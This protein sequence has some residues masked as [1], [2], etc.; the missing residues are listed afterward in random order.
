MLD[1]QENTLVSPQHRR[2]ITRWRQLLEGRHI[3]PG[4]HPAGMAAALTGTVATL[5][6]SEL[7]LSVKGGQRA[8]FLQKALEK[9]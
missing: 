5:A 3:P 4:S 2:A 8:E 9:F 1:L 6:T 7:S